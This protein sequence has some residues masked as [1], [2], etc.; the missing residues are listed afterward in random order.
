VGNEEGTRAGG[1]GDCGQMMRGGVI[2]STRRRH[3]TSQEA[4]LLTLA[5]KAVE[6]ASLQNTKVRLAR[7]GGGRDLPCRGHSTGIASD[8]RPTKTVLSVH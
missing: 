2:Q 5:Q 4:N 6:L 1:T 8:T 7:G 3:R